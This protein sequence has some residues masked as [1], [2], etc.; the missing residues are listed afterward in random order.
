MERLIRGLSA[1]ACPGDFYHRESNGTKVLC[2]PT[3][4]VYTRQTRHTR[5][6]CERVRKRTLHLTFMHRGRQTRY[7]RGWGKGPIDRINRVIDYR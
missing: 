7:N 3:F 4:I 2:A 5:R 1:F 6:I